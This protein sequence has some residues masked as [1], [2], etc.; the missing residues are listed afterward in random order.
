MKN[1]ESVNKVSHAKTRVITR[2]GR[3]LGDSV[4]LAHTFPDEFRF[5]QTQYPILF[6]RNEKGNAYEAVVLFGFEEEENLFLSPD[7]GWDANYIP[8]MVQRQPFHIGFKAGKPEEAEL[9][10]LHINMNSP[11]VSEEEGERLFTDSGETSDFLNYISS[12]L[13]TI[14]Q[15]G[16]NAQEFYRELIRYELI[17]SVTFDITLSTGER[18]QLIG[19]FTINEDKLKNLSGEAL[20]SLNKKGILL[21][22]YM[23]IA[24]I[25]NIKK[26]IARKSQKDS[27]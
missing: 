11:R 22:V 5:L 21:A 18:S 6:Q 26:L 12:M 10:I 2:R 24:S 13:E 17:E 20:E 27:K 15:W 19:F 9:R 8:L 16:Q 7:G 1:I 14:H 25:D 4:M 3:E 23:V